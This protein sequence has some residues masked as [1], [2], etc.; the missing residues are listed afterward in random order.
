MGI[1]DTGKICTT[2][3]AELDILRSEIKGITT[4]IKQEKDKIQESINSIAVDEN[5]SDLS[6]IEDGMDSVAEALDPS[7]ASEDVQSFLKCFGNVGIKSDG[8]GLDKTK[9]G[10]LVADALNTEM[11]NLMSTS[12]QQIS[13]TLNRLEGLIS[14][15]KI[16]RAMGLSQ[17]LADCPGGASINA[18]DLEAELNENL[19]TTSGEVDIDGF[20]KGSDIKDR[21]KSIKDKKKE[22]EKAM[23]N[24]IKGVI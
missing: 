10:N 14:V 23:A 17:C 11:D 19:I 3:N 7:N 20:D 24:K 15:D 21:V 1:I 18:V 5:L 16:D 13:D 12:E 2:L 6:E 4:P 22:A 8:L 9:T